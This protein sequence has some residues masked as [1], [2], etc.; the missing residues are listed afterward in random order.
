MFRIFLTTTMEYKSE[1]SGILLKYHILTFFIF[2]SHS[3][4][5]HGTFNMINVKNSRIIRNPTGRDGDFFGY[6]VAFVQGTQKTI[7]VGAPK[8]S[9]T[10]QSTVTRPGAL[11]KCQSVAS[12]Q[13]VRVDT[14]V[15][16][17]KE[18]LEGRQ[19]WHHKDNRWLGVSLDVSAAVL[20]CAHRWKDQFDFKT[21]GQGDFYMDGFCYEFNYDLER[22]TPTPLLGVRQNSSLPSYF[23]NAAM[24]MSAEYS[25]TTENL[26]LGAPGFNQYAGG[27]VKDT[28]VQD[29]F[30]NSI[31]PI[32][33]ADLYGYA[34]TSG[35]YYD[36]RTIYIAIGG[37]KDDLTGKVGSYFGAVLCTVVHKDFGDMLL[38]GAPFYASVNSQTLNSDRE[39][40]KVYVYIRERVN[41]PY[42]SLSLSVQL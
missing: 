31:D 32:G 26:L 17:I 27:F 5:I 18:T 30:A 28:K 13:E 38:V 24:G 35:H 6:S 19:L 33:N 2:V 16:N 39:E 41:I 3:V 36:G 11:Y 23:D 12:C 22:V 9:S 8:S 1:Y 37:P 4:H 7:L 20:V 42:F 14:T 21:T 15:G 34:V 29:K 40:G 25:K 10:Y